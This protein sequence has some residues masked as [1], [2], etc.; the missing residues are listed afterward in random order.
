MGEGSGHTVQVGKACCVIFSR[1]RTPCDAFVLFSGETVI[2]DRY[3][4]SGAA[5]TAAKGKQ[6][7]SHT[8]NRLAGTLSPSAHTQID[9]TCLRIRDC[10]ILEVAQEIIFSFP[11]SKC[12]SIPPHCDRPFKF[13]LSSYSPAWTGPRI[14]TAACP[15]P[16]PSSTSTSS[17]SA[18]SSGP[19]RG[20]WTA[21]SEGG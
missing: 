9:H 7:C 4:Y 5:F 16:T 21:S 17:R 6:R 2:A 14:P 13:S 1:V 10:R 3:A 15:A 20:P 19:T 12:T 8:P 18:H 11:P